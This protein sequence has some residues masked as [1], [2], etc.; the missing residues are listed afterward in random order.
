[1][2]ETP[3]IRRDHRERGDD[4]D[5]ATVAAEVTLRRDGRF[6]VTSLVVRTGW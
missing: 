3:P 1:M 4:D 6:M 5:L 2:S